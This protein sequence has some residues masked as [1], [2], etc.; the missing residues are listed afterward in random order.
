MPPATRLG[1]QKHKH[2]RAYRKESIMNIGRRT[3]TIKRL[4][5]SELRRLTVYQKTGIFPVLEGEARELI[6]DSL[7]NGYDESQPIV[8]WAA[9]GEIIDGRNRRDIAVELKLSDVPVAFVKFTNKDE[10]T[11][12]VVQANLARRHLSRRELTQLRKQL[13]GNGL[14]PKKVAELTGV[15]PSTVRKQTVVER[16]AAKAQRD[17]QLRQKVAAGKSQRQ[18]AHELGIGK[19]TVVD[20]V[21]NAPNARKRPAAAEAKQGNDEFREALEEASLCG[22]NY[23]DAMKAL[24]LLVDLRKRNRPSRVDQALDILSQYLDKAGDRDAVK[25]YKAEKKPPTDAELNMTLRETERKLNRIFNK[26]EAG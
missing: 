19:T 18:V 13:V 16:A 14:P 12:Y 11:A 4:S 6:R 9:T 23:D 2:I 8:V 3:A 20:V 7:S 1:S 17:E 5:S 21:G 26:T 25:A 15:H 22:L 24:R 10:V